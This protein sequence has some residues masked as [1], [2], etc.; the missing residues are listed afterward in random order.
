M[1]M[2]HIA[3]EMHKG[4]VSAILR[5]IH[6]ENLFLRVNAILSG[7]KFQ[8]HNHDFWEVV[9]ESL[10][11]DTV[12]LGIPLK[13]IA[14]AAF[15]YVSGKEYQGDDAYVKGLIANQFKY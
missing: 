9:K 10:N 13:S 2:Q 14:E 4:N 15:F 6:S 3:D 8:I 12:V 5:G 11:D 7:A 1:E